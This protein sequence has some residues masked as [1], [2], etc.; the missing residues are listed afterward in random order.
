MIYKWFS[1]DESQSKEVQKEACGVLMNLAV[2]EDIKAFIASNGAIP[3]LVQLLGQGS[4]FI[5]GS[6]Y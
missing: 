1:A 3:K 6:N 5:K 2:N 4:H